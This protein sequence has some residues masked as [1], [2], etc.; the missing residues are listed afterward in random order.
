MKYSLLPF[1]Y[2]N[3]FLACYLVVYLASPLLKKAIIAS[4]EKQLRYLVIIFY[5]L[6]NVICFLA[7]NTLLENWFTSPVLFV[8]WLFVGA[9]I[10]KGNYSINWKWRLA[11]IGA[12]LIGTT[13]RLSLL[14]SNSINTTQHDIEKYFSY[15]SPFL[16]VEAAVLFLEFKELK[17]KQNKFINTIS[18][19]TLGVYLIHD[20]DYAR[21]TIWHTLLKTQNYTDSSLLFLYLVGCVCLIFVLS[22]VIDLIRMYFLE[23]P[24]FFL[25]NKTH[26]HGSSIS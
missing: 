9:W 5:V 18:A 3:W 8:F 25:V 1:L 20:N 22:S 23:H 14:Y 6:V 7:R 11:G 2:G 21:T 17:I 19:T 13:I 10:Q 4:T 16:V 15:Y 12:F 24:F 26:N